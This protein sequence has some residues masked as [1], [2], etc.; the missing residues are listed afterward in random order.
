MKKWKYIGLA[1]LAIYA[2]VA[3]PGCTTRT[4][5]LYAETRFSAGM[6]G[7]MVT[8]VSMWG[9]GPKRDA[10]ST[11]LGIWGVFHT[12]LFAWWW[13]T[14]M[15]P[16]DLYLLGDGIGFHVYD[17]DGRPVPKVRITAYGAESGYHLDEETDEHGHLYLPRRER[18]FNYV[19][20]EKTGP[21]SKFPVQHTPYNQC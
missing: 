16:Y 21:A 2:L 14:L 12:V 6:A 1:F 11:T 15:L 20:A 10:L 7:V 17:Q 9:S 19:S 3:V 4:G 13:D 8:G 5:I 18:S